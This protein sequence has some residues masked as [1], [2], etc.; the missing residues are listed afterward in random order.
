ML[1]PKS[2]QR[3]H[4]PPT[5]Q[6][7]PLVSSA[8]HNED[9][10]AKDAEPD[11]GRK[12]RQWF[13]PLTLHRLVFRFQYSRL[14]HYTTKGQS[15]LQRAA[16]LIS[17]N[18]IPLPFFKSAPSPGQE[19]I[20]GV[21]LCMWGTGTILVLNMVLTIIAIAVA[22]SRGPDSSKQLEYAELYRGSCSVTNGWTTGMHLVINAL[23][24]ALLAAS[25]YSMQCLSAPTRED[26]SL[27][28]AQHSWLDIGTFSIRN[29]W[30]MDGKRKALWGVLFLSSVPIHMMYNS[31]VFP[32]ITTKQYGIVVLPDDL[33]ENES[34]TKD[35]YE[36][37]V[38]LQ[39]VGEDPAHVRAE[40][41]DGTFKRHSLS[42]CVEQYNNEYNT[43]K[44]TL[45]LVA[46]REYFDESS[47]L[48]QWETLMGAGGRNWLTGLNEGYWQTNNSIAVHTG[49]WNYADW[50]FRDPMNGR[51]NNSTWQDYDAFY[52]SRLGLEDEKCQL[53]FSLPI[54]L[55]VVICN[56]I[57][58]I[59]MYL[60][61]RTDR[62]GVLLTVGD[63]L[64]SFLDKPDRMT[65][66]RC[67]LSRHDMM[68]WHA[69]SICPS[70]RLPVARYP[71]SLPR[72]ELWCRSTGW[73]PWTWTMGLFFSCLAPS[74][75]LY[76][77]GI[78]W[79]EFSSMDTSMSYVWSLEMGKPTGPTIIV[80]GRDVTALVLLAN[81]PQLVYSMLYFLSNGLLT[82]MLLAAEYNDYATKRKSLRVSWPKGQQ[83]LFLVIIN[84]LDVHGNR[85]I[86]ESKTACSFSLK[87][88]FLTILV[89]TTAMAILI[90]LGF[91][92]LRSDMPV[93][94]SCS[95]A[96]SAACHPPP[97]DT[98]A[99]LKP[100][101]W[102]E[103]IKTQAQ[104]KDIDHRPTDE[105]SNDERLFADTDYPH[106][107]F[108]SREVMKPSRDIRYL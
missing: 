98:D 62:T 54:C 10:D 37:G 96:I 43:K 66:G 36:T 42:E 9:G 52:S 45:L 53:Y 88:M 103:I 48:S 72:S 60:T 39:Q 85:A 14:G 89:G 77:G 28:H 7:S 6:D 74:I 63:A 44:G 5:S 78:S 64:S 30:A 105:P 19:W 51:T 46:D 69:L 40:Y 90:G 81:S 3:T 84:V 102:G 1:T 70:K 38:F 8:S 86:Y 100:V 57:K 35:D 58:V 87:A 83:R 94:S 11:Y 31:A 4:Q 49:H 55:A 29:L 104:S 68:G 2:D 56:I 21:L 12:P 34:L 73:G 108:T 65:K 61:A 23:S 92:R 50:S 41:R 80:N 71:E 32:S 76:I 99:S 101:K 27:A 106:C 47:S 25:N 75:G 20:K 82:N 13:K 15:F 33:G 18:E 93:A 17:F 24:T 97:G 16:H 22:Y 95:A 59:C 67:F 91:R 79:A 26:I 107:S